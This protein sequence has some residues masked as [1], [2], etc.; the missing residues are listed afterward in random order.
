MKSTQSSNNGN[1]VHDMRMK[2]N[3]ALAK[4]LVAR[5]GARYATTPHIVAN[6]HGRPGDGRMDTRATMEHAP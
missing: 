3:E 1:E 6:P 2:K 4:Q 5:H